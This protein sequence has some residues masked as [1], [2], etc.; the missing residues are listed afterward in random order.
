MAETREEYIKRQQ[1]RKAKAIQKAEGIK[2]TT[3][4]RRVQA[5]DEAAGYAEYERKDDK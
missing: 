2:Y 5:A 1:K 3:A 4:L